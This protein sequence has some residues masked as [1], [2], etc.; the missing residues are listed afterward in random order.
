M[1]DYRPKWRLPSSYIN[2]SVI[3]IKEREFLYKYVHEVL[4]TNM[5]FALLKTRKDGNCDFCNEPEH[6]MHIFYFSSKVYKFTLMYSI[7]NRDWLKLLL[8]D[9]HYIRN[10]DKN[11]AI[12]LICNYLYCIWISRVKNF[13]EIE[14]FSFLKGKINYCRWLLKSM[15]GDKLKSIV[16]N[17]FME[18]VL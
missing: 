14:T 13:N 11:T 17:G 10:R 8:C 12:L 3:D 18:E 15:Y 16:T 6:T 4:P 7:M 1:L 5:R 2:N 9:F